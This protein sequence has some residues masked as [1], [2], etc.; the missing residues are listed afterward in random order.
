MPTK[1]DVVLVRTVAIL[2]HQDLFVLRAIKAALTCIG[3]GPDNQVLEFGI[4]FLARGQSFA[5][6]APVHADV[7][8][9][10][11]ARVVG[12]EGEGTRE[13]SSEFSARHFAGCRCKLTVLDLA[14]SNNGSNLHVVGGIREHH[15]CAIAPH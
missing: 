11:F 10:A 13:K 12:G 4:D 5:K 6:M 7:M 2:E 9:G 3:L 15:G 14:A 8:D 1:F